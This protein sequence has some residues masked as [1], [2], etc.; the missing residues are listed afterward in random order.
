MNKKLNILFA[1]AECIPFCANGGVAEMCHMLPKYLNASGEV[2]IR[3]IMPLYSTIPEKYRNE[4]R[5]IGEKT[6]NLSWRNSYCAIYEYKRRG[7]IFYFISNDQYF[8]REQLFGYDD[9]IERFTFFSRAVLDIIPMTGFFPDIIHA[10]DWQS[11][12]ICTFLKI[13]PWQNPKYEHIKT[14]LQVHNLAYQGI[15]DFSVVK[16]VL[17]VEDKFA[18]LFDYFGKAN[19]MK[20]ALLCTDEIVAVS[21]SYAEEIQTHEGG[22]GLENIFVDSKHKLHGIIN[23]IDYSYYNPSIDNDI[24]TNYDKSSLA[25]KVENKLKLQKDLGLEI[26]EDI[27]VFAIIGLMAEHKGIDLLLQ[28]IDK[29]LD[30]GAELIAIGHGPEDY[31]NKMKALQEKFPTRVNIK[32]G[33]DGSYVKKLYSGSDFLFNL[34]SI[35][36]CGLCPLVANRYGSLPIVYLTGGIKDNCTDFKYQNGNAYILKN[37]DGT[38]LSDLID[39]ALRDFSDKE[40]FTSYMVSAM[41]QSFDITDC[42]KQYLELYHKMKD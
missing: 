41:N 37:Y 24:Y 7:I 31:E 5:L 1:T 33:F 27:P 39:R 34:A 12:T 16:D 40:K 11:G 9:D 19:L 30:A 10:N 32:F 38:S 23:G 20:A 22:A 36:P 6:V 14:V 42:A 2:D 26:G 4:F 15:A 8:N 29:Y 3:V 21:K 25:A 17:D 18:Y 35:E 28:V 13:L